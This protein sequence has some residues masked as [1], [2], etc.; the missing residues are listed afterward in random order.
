MLKPTNSRLVLT[1]QFYITELLTHLHGDAVH[2][3]VFGFT[4]T[5]SSFYTPGDTYKPLQKLLAKHKNVGISL[6]KHNVYCFDS[7]S[8][9]FLVALL[10]TGRQ[11]EGLKDFESSWD[12]S[13]V[14]SK[15]LL[16]HCRTLPRHV[17]KTTLS[18]NKAR[19]L[20]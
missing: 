18:L 3:I 14:E 9:R 19:T 11:M 15:R 2:N 13:V 1:F 20:T 6:S 7:E 8:F 12:R 4:N 16:A 5:R 10:V 17:V